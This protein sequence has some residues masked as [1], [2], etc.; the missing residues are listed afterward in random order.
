LKAIESYSIKEDR[1]TCVEDLSL[2][3]ARS[4]ASACPFD[5]NTVYVF[6]GY[7]K[8]Q[9]TLTS[10]EKLT[11][12][13]PECSPLSIQLPLPLRRFASVKIAA[14]KIL[15]LGGLQRMSKDS[16][17]VFCLDVLEDGYALEQLDKIDRAGA[18]DMPVLVDSVGQV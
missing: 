4:Q 2:S 12:S 15:L 5:D 10:M 3:V 14:S 17:S 6:G 9:G 7:N 18:V 11:L 13:P 1:W 16:D 8:D